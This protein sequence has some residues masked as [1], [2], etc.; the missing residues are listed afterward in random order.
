MCATEKYAATEK[1]PTFHFMYPCESTH[2]AP[3]KKMPLFTLCTS[4]NTLTQ[5]QKNI[6]LFTYV[7]VWIHSHRNRKT[8]H[9]SLMYQCEYTHTETEKHTTFHLCTSVNTL[10]QKQKNIPLFTY[11]PVWIHSHR[12]RKTHHFSLH[13]PTWIYSHGNRR[14]N[15]FSLY[16]PVWIHSALLGQVWEVVKKRSSNCD[17]FSI[18]PLLLFIYIYIIVH[19]YNLW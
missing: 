4:V 12:N 1:Y 17:R 11:V 14:R 8:H 6:P 16:V 7:P 18:N 13:V 19:Y 2:I 15:N 10:T 3:E 5:K 9:F